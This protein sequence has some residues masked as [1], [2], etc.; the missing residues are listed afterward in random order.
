V[1][2]WFEPSERNTL[3]QREIKLYCCV[4]VAL[5]KAKLNLRKVEVV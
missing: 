2:T 4:C 5:F 3:R 1:L